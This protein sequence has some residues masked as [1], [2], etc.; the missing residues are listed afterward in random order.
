MK[1]FV[2]VP[3]TTANLGPGFDVLGG[4]LDIYN[5]IEFYEDEKFDVNF[6]GVDSEKINPEDNYFIKAIKL[7][8]NFLEK[9]PPKG[10][11]IFKNNIPIGKGL[12]SSASAIILGLSIPFLYYLKKIDKENFLKLALEIEGHLDNLIPAYFGGVRIS[13]KFGEKINSVK[14]KT[15]KEK[16]IL[17][18]PKIGISTEKARA[19]LPKKLDLKDAIFNIQRVCLVIYSFESKNY[20]FLKSAF[21]DRIHQNLRMDLVRGLKD[22][23]FKILENRKIIGGWLSGSGS[24]LAFLIKE[25]DLLNIKEYIVNLIEKFKFEASILISEFSNEGLKYSIYN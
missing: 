4:A 15:P 22:L 3:A 21:E 24:T 18:V 23:F 9:E 5:E 7:G 2:K 1:I 16:L 25:K 12:G 14:L 20:K 13:F 6:K 8:S 11:I 17:I 19:I 10:K